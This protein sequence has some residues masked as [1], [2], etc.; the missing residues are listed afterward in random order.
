MHIAVHGSAVSLDLDHTG[1]EGPCPEVGQAVMVRG[2]SGKPSNVWC[3]GLEGSVSSTGGFF[4][5]KP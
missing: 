5:P 4:S 3:E 2:R 1:L